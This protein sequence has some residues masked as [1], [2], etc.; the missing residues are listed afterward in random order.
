MLNIAVYKIS[1][2]FF[3]IHWLR[4]LCTLTRYEHILFL[5]HIEYQTKIDHTFSAES[6]KTNA[7][8]EKPYFNSNLRVYMKLLCVYDKIQLQANIF[9]I[10]F[11]IRYI[12]FYILYLYYILYIFFYIIFIFFKY[13][14]LITIQEYIQE[15]A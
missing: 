11:F 6:V 2:L 8:I 9:Y 13:F 12:L 14:L 4:S 15:K 10:I 1:I 7:A 3:I 5:S